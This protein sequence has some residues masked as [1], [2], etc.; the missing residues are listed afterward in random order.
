[1]TQR[2][3]SRIVHNF[4][5][6]TILYPSAQ[7]G[8]LTQPSRFVA[9]GL[10]LSVTLLDGELRAKGGSMQARA[11]NSDDLSILPAPRVA[12]CF[13][14]ITRSLAHTRDSIERHVL[15]PSGDL[16]PGHLRVYGHFFRQV[17]IDNPRS[18]EKGALD[19]EAHRMLPLDWIRL[20]DPD[21]CLQ[22]WNFD[23]L[24]AWGDCWNDGFRSLRNLVHQLHSL[25]QVSLAALEDG[26]DICI[27]CRPDLRYHDSLGPVLVRAMKTGDDRV[28][29]PWWQAHGGQNDR[30]AIAAGR[31]AITA[32]GQRIEQALAFCQAGQVPLNSE[33]LLD[34]ALRQANIP[35]TRMG[36]RA[37]RVRL[38]GVQRYEDFA[39]PSVSW[40]KHRIR[41]WA[42]AVT[43]FTG[44]RPL[45]RSLLRR[46]RP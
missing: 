18:G 34:F 25:R 42:A 27:F 46:L 24:K 3:C 43:D 29:L 9:G 38:D 22:A 4:C 11:Q 7:H 5:L 6:R 37:S 28:F 33:H 35:V 14:G 21:L 45:A 44:L 17:E 36:C 26:A 1:M 40:I 31:R 32:Y 19:P 23:G 15:T 2:L 20:E 16:S 39:R 41:P 13:F 12:I 30:F 8:T 10:R